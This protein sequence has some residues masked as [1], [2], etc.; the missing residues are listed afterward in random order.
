[1]ASLERSNRA[2]KVESCT[3]GVDICD[4]E[5]VG[6][7]RKACYVSFLVLSCEVVFASYHGSQLLRD[8]IHQ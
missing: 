2:L 1:M 6:T 4:W 3:K 5:D 8:D 7:E